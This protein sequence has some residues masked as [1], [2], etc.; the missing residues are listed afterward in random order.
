MVLRTDK[1]VRLMKLDQLSDFLGQ[2]PHLGFHCFT[3]AESYQGDHNWDRLYL[4]LL[5]HLLE[6]FRLAP[7]RFALHVAKVAPTSM[8]FVPCKDGV[9]HNE[10]EDA[11][12][13]DLEAGCNVLLHAMLR[14]AKA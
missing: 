10:A 14:M 11:K 2:L 1:F 13:E 5:L 9:S 7:F 4:P 3:E 6:I 12:S 8:I